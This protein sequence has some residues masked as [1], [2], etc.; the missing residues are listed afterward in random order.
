MPSRGQIDQKGQTER[1]RL[2]S[3]TPMN[4]KIKLLLVGKILFGLSSLFQHKNTITVHILT[5]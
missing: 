3:L 1:W 2:L 5:G 4:F